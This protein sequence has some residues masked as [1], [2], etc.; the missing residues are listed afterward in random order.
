MQKEKEFPAS[1]IC[2]SPT[3]QNEFDLAIQSA[4]IEYE[5]EI[6]GEPV[7][8]MLDSGDLLVSADSSSDGSVVTVRITAKHWEPLYNA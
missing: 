8:R 3:A 7:A 1:L 2:I 6:D 4:E 5:T